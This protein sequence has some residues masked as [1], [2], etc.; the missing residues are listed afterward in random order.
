MSP[1][2]RAGLIFGGIALVAVPLL[3]MLN[4]VLPFG[5]LCGTVVSGLLGGLAG[6]YALRWQGTQ[7]VAQGV[8]AGT[9]AGVG[10][11]IG[12][13]IF[14]L[15]FFGIVMNTPEGQQLMQQQFQ[16][17]MQQQGQQLSPEELQNLTALINNLIG[18]IA[19]GC[20]GILNLL[21]ALGGG[22]LGALVAQRRPG[23]TPPPAAP[24]GPPPMAPM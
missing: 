17:G 19:G 10:T 2:V 23:D 18:P 11:L 16:Q 1:G 15:V 24:F 22:A 8:L 12:G 9:L 13:I 20:M 6:F 3:S 14:G 21:I 7:T 4:F 5:C